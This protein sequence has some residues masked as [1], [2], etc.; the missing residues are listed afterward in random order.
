MNENEV[1]YSKLN[2]EIRSQK[3]KMA[4]CYDFDKTLS[5]DDMQ[6]F[7]LIPSFGIDKSEF[8][9]SS[10]KLA[11]ENLMDTNLAWMHELIR[12][13]EF[14]RKSL[15]REYFRETGSDVMLY[16]GV[17]TWFKRMNEYAEKKG[18]ELEHYIIS[19][20]L[21]EIIEGSEI[22]P[23]FKRIYASTYLYS[24]DGVAKWPAQAINYT[25]KTQFI[26]RIA[27]GF[28]EEYDERVNDSLSDEMLRIPYENIVY[29][30]DS[31]TDIPCMRLVKSKGGYSIGVFDPIKNNRAKVY[32]LFNDG[33]LSFYSPA[34]YYANS[35]LSKFMK[36]IIDEISAKE[37]IKTECK[38]LKQ[39]AEA[40]K[41]KKSIEDIAKAYPGKISTKD[42]RE[43][44]QMTNALKSLIPGN[45]D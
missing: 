1:L 41:M 5:P 28:L 33:R 9:E 16:K 15:K 26:F 12:Y 37:S 13:S 34:D 31:A 40:F 32:Q 2:D 14:K 43:L 36:Q 27:K 10:N 24:A 4:I 17:K 23:Y 30:G 45:I 42:K 22:A 25:N 21:K 38:I 19:S 39:P 8:W 44:E 29:I 35:E 6:T 3:P 20:G 7:T 18:I 11:K